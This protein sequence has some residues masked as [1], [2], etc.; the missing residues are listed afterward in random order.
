MTL[1]KT[2]VDKVRRI[3]NYP[4]LRDPTVEPE[5]KGGAHFDFSTRDTRIGQA[6][7]DNLVQRS[8]I[9][10]EEC[11]EGILTHEF[12]HYMVFPKTLSQIILSGKMIHD[13]FS[14]KGEERE[15]FIF[16]T[17][18][19]MNDDVASVLDANRRESILKM[20]TASQQTMPNEVNQNVRAVMLGYL[21][22]QAGR[23]Y[24]LK[25]ELN[26][27]LERMLQ[28][29]FLDPKTNRPPQDAQKLRLSLFQFGDIINDMI[30]KY[31]KTPK[32]GKEK[33][34]KGEGKGAEYTPDGSEFGT[35]GDLD[36]KEIIGKAREG[37][38]KKA[39]RE[40]SDVIS[41]G[42]Y[43]QVKDWLK[44][45]QAR[46]PQIPPGERDISVG[47]SRGELTVDRETV[48][49]YRELSKKY[50]LIVHKKPVET[51]KIKKSLEETEKWRVG[52][53]PL[54]AMPNLSGGLF[55]PGITRKVKINENKVTTTDY[56]VPHLLAVIDSSGS[57][58]HPSQRKSHAVLAGHC[59]ARS[60]HTHG[61]AIGVINF[62]G[63][64]F[65]LPYT[66][67]L[68]EA[69]GEITAHQG[70]GTV[71]DIEILKKMLKPEE[72]KI[73]EE[74]P[75]LHMREIPREAIKKE[76][77]LPYQVFEKALQSG[78]IDL[79]MFTDG[80]IA[81]LGEVV[82]LFEE[83]AT[84]HRGTII[85]TH[86][87]AQTIPELQS[88]KINVYSID[89]EEDIPHIVLKDVRRNF[90]FHASNYSA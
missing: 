56:D 8:E 10:E 23:Q 57:M 49:Y 83:S 81:N 43:K 70:G 52:R 78:S 31:D 39:L 27:Y 32:S 30:D 25:P 35:P 67:N 53:E 33:G 88:D 41:R 29:E 15:G 69:L 55:L 85:L 72:F 84:L 9:T 37:D 87:Y 63:D 12:G 16:Q 42:E 60:Y 34:E 6:Y 68:E 24:E 17:F 13:F 64:S 65:Y 28:I 73:I 7:V 20:R 54:L 59:A 5:I 3:Y 80:G 66:R 2:T 18:A 79:L 38:I 77:Q 86:R 76:I 82:K 1:Q 11:L 4:A 48:D 19:D 46:V 50:P 71:V 90:N 36:I 44:E 26:S 45:Q 40:I 14:D 74:N 89:N 21:N 47:T 75:E 58:P 62:S 61:S 22:R 51:R